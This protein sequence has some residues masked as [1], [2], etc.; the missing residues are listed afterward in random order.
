MIARP[1]I[2][3]RV[4]YQKDTENSIPEPAIAVSVDANGLIVLQQGNQELLINHE[5]VKDLFKAI[6]QAKEQ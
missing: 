1:L 5:S 3:A 2:N 4:V 6:K